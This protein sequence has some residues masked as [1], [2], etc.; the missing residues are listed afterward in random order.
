MPTFQVMSDLHLEFQ[1][2]DFNTSWIK[3]GTDALLLAGDIDVFRGIETSLKE[4][5]IPTYYVLGNHEYYRQRW[6]NNIDVFQEALLGNKNI[7]VLEDDV[8]IVDGTRIIGAT[9]W[10]DFWV[11]HP[12]GFRQNRAHLCRMGMSDFQAIRGVST[13]AWAERHQQSLKYIQTILQNPFDGPTIVMTHMA[14]SFKSSHP[15]YA[16]S[17]I[18]TGFCSELDYFIEE[19]QPD[20]WIHGHCHESFD[21]N[22][23]KTRVICNPYGYY[24]YDLNPEFNNN[25]LIRT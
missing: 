5:N 11:T 25:L 1:Q 12:G 15:K 16:K 20:Y 21:Y 17:D 8:V 2:R 6:E 19:Y 7:H 13:G 22:I 4:I 9:L 18:S 23:G 14:P 3:P 24:P 10:T